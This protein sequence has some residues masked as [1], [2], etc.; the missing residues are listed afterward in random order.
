MNDGSWR[1]SC[2]NLRPARSAGL[3]ILRSW[4]KSIWVAM[5]A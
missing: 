2:V 1:S 5:P 3:R 4:L